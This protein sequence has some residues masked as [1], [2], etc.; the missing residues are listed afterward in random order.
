M[1]DS[2]KFLKGTQANLTAKIAAIKAGTGT[3]EAGAFYLTSDTDRLYFAQASN[4]LVPLNQFI[5]TVANV[6]ALEN[7]TAA[8]GDYYYCKSENVLAVWDASEGAN[9]GWVQLNPD[10]NNRINNSTSALSAG[11]SGNN[12]TLNMSV[13]DDGSTPRQ[14]TGTVTLAAG[15]NITLSESNNTVTITAAATNDTTYDLG[16]AAATGLSTGQSGAKLVLDASGSGTD[17][18]VVIKS[19]NSNLSISQSNDVITLTA[20]DQSVSTVSANFDSSGKFKVGVKDES[21][22]DAVYSTEITPTISYGETG[23]KSSATFNS[24]TANLDVYTTTQVDS[25]IS[26]AL[27]AADALTYKGT[28]SSSDA[29]T[30]LVGTAAFGTVYKVSNTISSPVAAKTGDLVIAEQ[31]GNNTEGSANGATWVV[32]PSGDDQTI[33]WVAN[34]TTGQVGSTDG[35]NGAY[36]K[37]AAGTHTA[38]SHSASGSVIT[39]TVGQAADYTAQTATGSASD[40]SLTPATSNTATSAEFTAVTGIETDVYGNVVNGSVKTAKFTV[41]DSHANINSVSQTSS[42]SNNVATITTTVADTDAVSKSGTMT[43]TSDNLTLTASG[44][45]TKL[46]LEW[47][48]F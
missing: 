15:N 34:A 23:A 35:T 37:V 46:N 13:T 25:K 2:V 20:A 32:V 21:D 26:S 11:T 39:T 14:A 16:S 7:V 17:S 3:V 38:V 42:V 8:D 48:T 9:G 22:A 10:T 36:I 30:K 45:Q 12:V 44:S 6:A 18:D 41:K 47:G 27:S 19:A 28:V 31:N 29:S 4:E 40:V 33:T 5:R 1:A 43:L 24:G